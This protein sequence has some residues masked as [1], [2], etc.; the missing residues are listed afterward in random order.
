MISRV[1]DCCFL[2]VVFG[3]VVLLLRLRHLLFAITA[4]FFRL[5]VEST[6]AVKSHKVSGQLPHQHQQQWQL[7]M[8]GNRNDGISGIR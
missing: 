4:N 1:V 2:I 7:Q 5:I 8:W 6:L 3:V